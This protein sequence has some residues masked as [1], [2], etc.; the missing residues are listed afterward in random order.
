[1][2]V[3]DMYRIRVLIRCKDGKLLRV[4]ENVQFFYDQQGNVCSLLRVPVFRNRAHEL[5][6][7]W[8]VCVCVVLCIMLC[9]ML[10]VCVCVG[11]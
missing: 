5:T 9:V 4:N 7:V 2:T 10:C 11:W 3:S 8:C 6:L 1:M